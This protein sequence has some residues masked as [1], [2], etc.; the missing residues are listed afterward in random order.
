MASTAPR[1]FD[2]EPLHAVE[3]IDSTRYRAIRIEVKDNSN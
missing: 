2:P 1:W 3:N